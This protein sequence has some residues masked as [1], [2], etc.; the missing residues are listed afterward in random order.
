MSHFRKFPHISAFT[1]FYVSGIDPSSPGAGFVSSVA[2]F[3]W[4]SVNSFGFGFGFFFQII[5]V[6]TPVIPS[7]SI[8]VNRG[9]LS[10]NHLRDDQGNQ[11]PEYKAL[12]GVIGNPAGPTETV[13]CQGWHFPFRAGDNLKRIRAASHYLPFPGGN[14]IH[15]ATSASPSR[16]TPA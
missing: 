2:F 14:R 10:S 15:T 9:I 12:Q 7:L 8:V 3:V 16:P 5:G 6:L 11:N 13:T 4:P 1:A